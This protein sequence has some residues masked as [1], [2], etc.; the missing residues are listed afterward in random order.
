MST[1]RVSGKS[2]PAGRQHMS[3]RS[4]FPGR[5]ERGGDREEGGVTWILPIGKKKEDEFST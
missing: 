3:G 4:Q 1:K 5:R 2:C